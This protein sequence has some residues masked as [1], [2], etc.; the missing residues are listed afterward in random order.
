LLPLIDR[1]ILYTMFNLFKN[2]LVHTVVVLS[3]CYTLQWTSSSTPFCFLTDA[4]ELGFTRRIHFKLFV[5]LNTVWDFVPDNI[6]ILTFITPKVLPQV[7]YI[8]D[9]WISVLKK[10]HRCYHKIRTMKSTPL[11][12]GLA[13]KLVLLKAWLRVVIYYVN[14]SSGFLSYCINTCLFSCY[15]LQFLYLCL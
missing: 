2:D 5:V 15:Y 1:L 8:F 6:D 13:L 10:Q 7:R 14:M 4:S 12:T 9:S 11:L 3:L